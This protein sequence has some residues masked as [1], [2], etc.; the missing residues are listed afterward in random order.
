[1]QAS[2]IVRARDRAH[3]IEATLQALRSQT[4]PVEIIVVDSGSTDGT[5]EI[6]QRYAD[7]VV[8]LP[9]SEFTYGG[10][11]NVGAAAA[12]GDV[13]F[14]L[15]AHC[16]PAY[17][18]WVERSISHYTDPAVAGT[19]QARRAPSGQLLR[20]PYAQ[21]PEDVRLDPYWGFSNHASSW[22]ADVWRQIPFREDLEACEDK[23]W[24]WR[25]LAAGWKI[26]YDPLLHVPAAHR[27]MESLSVMWARHR[28]EAS[29]LAALGAVPRPGVGELVHALRTT[30]PD[31]PSR[32]P[33]W[34]RGCSPWRLAKLGGDFV[35]ARGPH[36][37]A[38][39]TLDETLPIGGGVRNGA[40]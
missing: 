19:N 40:R 23:E 34:L 11:L 7:L 30:Q 38:H 9:Q 29:A 13:H 25:V 5:I 21:V 14:A 2:A 35:G 16:A 39:P 3:T 4:V 1:M 22:R 37:T 33:D 24:S 17:D 31:E 28:K 10:A 18:D 32:L 27:H 20:S 6:A 15:S 36:G 8:H 12:S 26:L